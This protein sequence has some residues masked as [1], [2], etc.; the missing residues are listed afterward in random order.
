MQLLIVKQ[1]YIIIIILIVI[2]FLSFIYIINLKKKYIIKLLNS[3]KRI[4][5][6]KIDFK[7]NLIQIWLFLSFTFVFFC[8][9]D[10]IKCKYN[11]FLNNK[12]L[13]F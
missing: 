5:N 3:N 1:S 12:K 13:F 2:F 7:S 9:D 4:F 8:L 11:L 6:H 10:W